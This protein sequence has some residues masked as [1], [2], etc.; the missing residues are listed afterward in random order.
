MRQTGNALSSLLTLLKN[1]RLINISSKIIDLLHR[2]FHR[3][4]L[5]TFHQRSPQ[6]SSTYKS[7]V[8]SNIS[9]NNTS[10]AIN[11]SSKH[12]IKKS[13]KN[14]VYHIISF[15]QK[16]IITTSNIS[17]KTPQK[18]SFINYIKYSANHF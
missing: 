10:K 11:F 3:I 14:N 13:S 4:F 18:S 8:S 15:H 1:H 16:S 2:I 6:K 7:N 17:L 12:F 5:R 9:S